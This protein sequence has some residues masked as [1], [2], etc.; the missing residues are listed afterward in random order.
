[1]GERL[2]ITQMFMT[3]LS[4]A[5]ATEIVF[6]KLNYYK[7]YIFEVQRISSILCLST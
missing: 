6:S 4:V 5:T 1:M 2:R 7:F 3:H